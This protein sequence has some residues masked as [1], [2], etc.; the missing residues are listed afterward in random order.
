M[1]P[2]EEL[3]DHIVNYQIFSDKANE[4]DCEYWSF[5]CD[6]SP[7]TKCNNVWNCKNG[8]DEFYC[9][10]TSLSEDIQKSF[11]CNNNE[12]Y[13]LQLINNNNDINMTC[14]HLNRTGDGIIDCIGGTDERLTNICQETYPIDIRKRFY[15]MNSSKCID[16]D[17]VCDTIIDCPFKD[18]EQICP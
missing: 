6:N 10:G 7:F 15:C 4:T 3:C 18:D 11:R 2:F 14:L 5:T 16:P 9:P 8:L 17:Q 1:Y 13:C 12:H